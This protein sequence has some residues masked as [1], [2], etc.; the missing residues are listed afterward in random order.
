M[1]LV[2]GVTPNRGRVEIFIDG[3]WRR[4]CVTRSGSDVAQTAALFC[5]RLGYPEVSFALPLNRTRDGKSAITSDFV[6]CTL[7]DNIGCTNKTAMCDWEFFISCKSAKIYSFGA[8][9]TQVRLVNSSLP[10]TGILELDGNGTWFKACG[11]YSSSALIRL[12]RH[13]C[14][15]LGY[16]GGLA[17]PERLS[18]L[19]FSFDPSCGHNTQSWAECSV[20]E[21]GR[22]SSY[23]RLHCSNSQWQVR[24]N[25]SAD[26]IEDKEGSIEVFFNKTWTAL[27]D[28][29]W[30]FNGA[31]VVCRQMGY[32]KALSANSSRSKSTFGNKNDFLLKVLCN[33]NETTLKDC[34]HSV[35]Q[36]KSCRAASTVCKKKE[37]KRSNIAIL[38]L[39]KLSFCSRLS[40]RMVSLRRLL[41]RCFK[42]LFF[43]GR[44]WSG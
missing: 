3:G 26:G 11:D 6:S 37:C 34:E 9:V 20:Y 28:D 39:A 38:F 16:E 25:S 4:M 2:D 35:M 22:C 23:L 13:V 19:F 43:H 7:T 44:V 41:L 10:N 40:L 32:Q 5:Q 8:Q 42:I 24:L 33:G 36:N 15:H 30:D 18:K 27:C 1:R 14:R 17:F 21:Y 12:S 29:K 31:E